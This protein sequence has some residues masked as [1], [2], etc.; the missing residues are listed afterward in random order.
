MSDS[1][2]AAVATTATAPSRVRGSGVLLP[3]ASILGGLLLWE[4]AVWAFDL[5]S[6]LLPAPSEVLALMVERWELL[7]DQ[8]GYTAFAATVGFVI[9]LGISLTL[10]ALIAASSTFERVINVWLVIIHAIPKVVV[11][12]LLLVWIGFGVKSS[13]IFVVVFTFFPILVNTVTGL[14]SADPDLLL[15]TRSMGGSTWQTLRAVRL[16]SALPS[17]MA[18]IKIS[19]TLAPL[20]AVIGEFVASNKGL[21]H[22]LIQSV[23]SLEVPTAFAAVVVV[24]ILGIAT[25]YFAEFVERAAIPWHAS[26]RGQPLD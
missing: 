19:I 13:I 8:L 17:I 25:W 4:L 22:M 3:T 16:P 21:G 1:P 6:Y 11:A 9:A 10:G 7:L 2:T 12:P 26:Q 5:P 23:G 18:G 15:L 20:G 14:R 24:S